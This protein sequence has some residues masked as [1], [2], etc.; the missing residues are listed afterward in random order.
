MAEQGVLIDG[1]QFLSK[2]ATGIG[3]YGRTLTR[4][5]RTLG[6]PVTVLYGR[7]THV[8]RDAPPHSLA[9]QVFGSEPPPERRL[10]RA[11]RNAPFLARSALGLTGPVRPD[12]VSTEGVDLNAFE[13]PLPS[14]DN[15]LNASRIYDR[16]HLHFTLKE[17][18]LEVVAP[19][20]IALAHWTG[21]MAL[22]AR[23]IPNVYTLH[24]L[25]PLQFPYFIVDRG[26]LSS[27]LHAAIARQADHIITVSEASKHHIV[28]LLKVPEDR[29]SV[30]YQPAPSLTKLEQSEAARLVETI[31]GAEPGKYALFLGAI[32]PKKNLKRLIEAFLMANPGIPLLLA[33]PKGWLNKED[34]ELI[35][36]VSTRQ[37]LVRQ[38]GY[39]P[40]R[41]VTALL[42]CARF[43]AF[44]SIYEGFGLPVLEAMQL[45][46]PVLTSNTSSLPEVAGDAAV[47]VDPLDMNQLTKGIRALTNDPDLRS[48]LSLRGPQQA[49][50]FS[51]EVYRHRLAEAYKKVGISMPQVDQQPQIVQ[52]AG[53]RLT[54]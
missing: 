19:A 34:L 45:G 33:G 18:L 27:R 6:V 35:Q 8:S 29:V 15:V 42:Q 21:P 16:A 9:T 24:D 54:V 3:S 41:H 2:T 48:E 47:L 28:D 30:T 10:I 32:E 1:L 39:L 20:G 13:P 36:T 49:A 12:K 7:S 5:L 38:L 22:K 44:P 50:K 4:T 43:F 40:R 26:G 37:S 31:Y 53:V 25:I 14:V 11:L 17:R 46:V 23:G 52:S 51:D